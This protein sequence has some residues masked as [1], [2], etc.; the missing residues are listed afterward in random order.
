MKKR[1]DKVRIKTTERNL[2]NVDIDSIDDFLDYE[3]SHEKK[4]ISR[5]QNRNKQTLKTDVELEEGLITEIMTNNMFKITLQDQ[6]ETA[7]MGGRLKQFMFNQRRVM[8]VGDKVKV[9]VSQ[10]T[11][12]RIEELIERKNRLMRYGEGSYQK[13]ILIAS[14]MDYAIIT[15]S[16]VEPMLKLGMIDRFIIQCGIDHIEPVICVNKIDLVDDL[17]YYQEM[18]EYYVECGY[19]TYFV[20]ATTGEGLPALKELLKGHLSVFSGQSGVGKSSV[21]NALMPGI[22]LKIGD[23]STF[24]EKGRHTTTNSRL[25]KWDFGGYLVDTPGIKTLALK[26]DNVSLVYNSF[27]GFHLFPCFFNDCSHIHEDNCGVLEAVENGKIPI[28]VYESYLRVIDSVN[29]E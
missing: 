4:A 29:Y 17:E 5:G 27:P 2:Q 22:N 19:K 28:N 6:E 9:D 7:L 26:R 16:C 21:I 18:L 23:I 8:A 15:V 10:G 25:I 20:S 12:F 13:E 24:N 1:K 14:N 11:P 3:Y